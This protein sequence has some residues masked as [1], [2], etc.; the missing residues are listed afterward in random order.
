MRRA[1]YLLAVLLAACG[2]DEAPATDRA[3]AA[4]PAPAVDR[5]AAGESSGSVRGADI[6]T[7]AATPTPS[8]VPLSRPA[9]VALDTLPG[10][11]WTR[12]DWAVFRDAVVAAEELGA[13]DL[14]LGEAVAGVGR[15]FVGF[16]Y[17]PQTLETPWL[18]AVSEG[19]PM[20]GTLERLVVNLREFDCVTFVENVLALTRFVRER[21]S[22]ALVDPEAARR[23][24][25][26]ELRSLRYR[27]GTMAG[28]ASR[29]HYFSEWLSDNAARGGLVL[30]HPALDPGEDHEPIDFMTTH[31]ASYPALADDP[32]SVARIRDV[33]ERL[34]ADLP[35]P[36][37]PEERIAEVA[38][39]IRSGDVIAATSTVAGLDVAHTGIAIRIDGE[40]RLM[41]APLV[42]SEVQISEV[43][44]AER[45]LRIEGQD[46][47]L[48]G[49]PTER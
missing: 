1:P 26:A 8:V 49:R 38:D 16:P 43:G 3:P 36:Y 42:G 23:A 14:P 10:S 6:E 33:E 40:L 4:D 9:E 25:E 19:R 12:A 34:N 22:E 47:V 2:G 37:V 15:L 17:T 20:D 30:V 18:E 24:Y 31:V 44:L 21:G 35:R 29:L 28:Y 27:G 39:G 41:H 48:V 46:G 13:R 45:I 5:A 11:I 32:A 7:E